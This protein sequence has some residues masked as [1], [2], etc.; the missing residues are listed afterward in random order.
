[1]VQVLVV[2]SAV[3]DFVYQMEHLPNLAEKYQA[4]DIQ[5]V[6]GGCAANAAVSI[7][8]LGGQAQLIARFGQDEIKDLVCDD[9]RAEGVNIDALS[10]SPEGRSAVSS[11][12]IDSRGERQIMAFRGQGLA[13]TPDLPQDANPDVVLADT[14]WPEATQRA[15]EKFP[16]LP[17][18]LD[19]EAPVPR[20]LAQA[21]SH[22]VFS[23]QGI[24]DFTG[25]QDTRA[26]LQAASKDLD[27][28]VAVTM[29]ADGVAWVESGEIVHLPGFQVD[30]VD[31]LG[32]GD[33]WHGAFALALAEG[34]AER[35]AAIFA[36]A[37]AALKCT[38]LGGRKASPDR[39]TVENF[40]KENK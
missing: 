11:V 14:R 9:L 32:A 17:R 7:S 35:D 2:G 31:T 26:A 39:E 20:K 30:A 16:N 6:G 29:G 3:L 21:A 37:V 40:L 5:I 24:T 38:Q 27:G 36:N 18:I 25:L 22:I 13:K 12:Y 8:R 34:K 33:A 10:I 15:F 4:Q 23:E 1:M 19:G 28:W